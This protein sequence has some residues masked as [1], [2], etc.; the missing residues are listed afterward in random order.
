MTAVETTTY[1]N[2]VGDVMIHAH[3]DVTDLSRLSDDAQSLSLL[4]IILDLFEF[5]LIVNSISCIHVWLTVAS[6]ASLMSEFLQ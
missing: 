6:T 3:A 4:M 1:N 5:D 2:P